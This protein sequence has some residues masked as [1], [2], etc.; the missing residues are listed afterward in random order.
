M[1]IPGREGYLYLGNV[2]SVRETV[3]SIIHECSCLALPNDVVRDLVSSKDISAGSVRAGFDGQ[4]TVSYSV[5]AG[6]KKGNKRR[7]SQGITDRRK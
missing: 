1:S 7:P 6:Q 3:E 5:V 2:H 4:L